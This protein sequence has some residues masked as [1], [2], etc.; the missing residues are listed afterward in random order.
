MFSLD[1]FCFKTLEW[2]VYAAVYIDLL[3]FPIEE[4]QLFSMV[5]FFSCLLTNLDLEMYE[6]V[7]LLKSIEPDVAD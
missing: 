5:S 1:V 4:T 7:E 3:L 2:L 6:L